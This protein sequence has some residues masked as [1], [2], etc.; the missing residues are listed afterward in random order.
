MCRRAQQI[1]AARAPFIVDAPLMKVIQI[2][3][4]PICQGA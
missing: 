1:F 4:K 3:K 2:D